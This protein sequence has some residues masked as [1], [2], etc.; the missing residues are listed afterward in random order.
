MMIS[1]CATFAIVPSFAADHVWED[2]E[3]DAKALGF[4]ISV[5]DERGLNAGQFNAGLTEEQVYTLYTEN[6]ADEYGNHNMNGTIA[7][8]GYDYTVSN[9]APLLTVGG[10]MLFGGYYN[11]EAESSIPMN[12]FPL[13]VDIDLNGEQTVGGIRTYGRIGTD[14]DGA[15]LTYKTYVMYAGESDWTFVKEGMS[16]NVHDNIDVAFDDALENVAKVRFQVTSANVVSQG[17]KLTKF[18][19]GMSAY[20]IIS[21]ITVLNEK[22]VSDVVAWT[23]APTVTETSSGSG[24]V[25]AN[26]ANSEILFDGNGVGYFNSRVY[27]WDGS[28][29]FPAYVTIDLGAEYEFSAVRIYGRYNMYGQCINQG[30]ISFSNN[31]TDWSPVTKHADTINATKEHGEDVGSAKYASTGGMY[32]DMAFSGDDGKYNA[33]GRYIRIECTNAPWPQ[34]LM[35]EVQLVKP[36]AGLETK[37]VA[38]LTGGGTEDP[39]TGIVEWTT[40]PTVTEAGGT[41][42]PNRTNSAALFDGK[43]AGNES[44]SYYGWEYGSMSFPVYFIVDLGK[45]YEFSAVRLYGRYGW[46]KQSMTSGNISVSSDGTTWSPKSSHTDTVDNVGQGTSYGSTGANY[47]DMAF[48]NGSEKCNARARYI[49]VECT[50]APWPQWLM[51]E[52]QL[53][54]PVDGLDYLTDSSDIMV[55]YK[56]ADILDWTKTPE[57]KDFV[58]SADT[59][60]LGGSG[61]KLFD[62]KVYGKFADMAKYKDY[63]GY[64]FA[65]LDSGETVTMT[66]DLGKEY[67]FSAVRVF[68][69]L[70]QPDQAM[71]QGNLYISDDG[72]NWST[73]LGHSDAKSGNG[74][75][76]IVDGGQDLIKYASTNNIYTDMVGSIAAKRV[77]MRARYIK[78]EV[79]KTSG[80]HF[81]MQEIM[82]VKPNGMYE[83][84]NAEEINKGAEEDP[85]SPTVTWKTLPT[86][87]DYYSQKTIGLSSSN[88]A[89]L[90]DGIVIREGVSD[91]NKAPAFGWDGCNLNSTTDNNMA[92]VTIDLGQEYEFSAVRVYGRYDIWFQ[93]MTE[94]NLFISSDSKTD[95]TQMWSRPLP[96]KDTV[97][98]TSKVANGAGNPIYGSSNDMY[99]DLKAPDGSNMKARYIRIQATASGAYEG[100]W[101]MQEIQ[102]VKPVEGKETKGY[103]DAALAAGSNGYYSE[104]KNV[105]FWD[106]TATAPKVIDR[107]TTSTKGSPN[108]AGDKALFDKIVYLSRAEHSENDYSAFI[109]NDHCLADGAHTWVTVDLGRNYTFSAIRLFPR[110]NNWDNSVTEANIYYSD[111]G[112]TW[113]APMYNKDNYASKR[114]QIVTYDSTG[115]CYTDLKATVADKNYNITARYIKIDITKAREHGKDRCNHVAIQELM[116]V[117]P[118]ASNTTYTVS[119][120]AKLFSEKAAA[121]DALIDAIGT[122]TKDSGDAIKKARAAY[123]ALDDYSKTLVTKLDVLEKAEKDFE[124][125]AA[126]NIIDAI[127]ALPAIGNVSYS[128]TEKID[129]VYKDYNAL[130]DENKNKITNSAKLIAVKAELAGLTFTLNVG[131]VVES[132]IG[133]KCAVFTLGGEK[134]IAKLIYN[135]V[136]YTEAD[137]QFTQAAAD[138]KTTLTVTGSYQADN[139]PSWNA[140][141]VGAALK[142]G[143]TVIINGDNTKMGLKKGDQ[144]TVGTGR[145]TRTI[146]MDDPMGGDHI[147]TVEYADGTTKTVNLITT[148]LTYSNVSNPGSTGASDEITPTRSWRYASASGGNMGK[149][150][151]GK[152]GDGNENY[153]WETEYAASPYL[154]DGTA[155]GNNVV[156]YMPKPHVFY[157]DLKGNTEGYNGVR[158]YNRNTG[159]RG[160]TVGVTDVWGKMAESDEWTKLGT[161]DLTGQDSQQPLTLTF[162]EDGSNVDYRFLMFS[163]SRFWGGSNSSNL[164]IGE[165]AIVKPYVT[166]IG[167]NTVITDVENEYIADISFSFNMAEAKSVAKV[168][169]GGTDIG[170]ANWTFAGNTITIAADYIKTLPAGKT[171]LTVTFNNGNVIPIYIERED[172]KTATYYITGDSAGNYSRGSDTLTLTALAGKTVSEIVAKGEKLTFSQSGNDI[173]IT[174]YNFRAADLWENYKNDGYIMLKIT[175]SDGTSADYRVILKGTVYKAT[176]ISTDGFK[177]DE[178]KAKTSWTVETDS[179]HNSYNIAKMF[180]NTVNSS[181]SG[182]GYNWHS[183]YSDVGGG[184]TPDFRKPHHLEIDFGELTEFSGI[185]YYRRNDGNNTAGVWTAVGIYGRNDVSEEWTEIK[186]YGSMAWPDVYTDVTL[187]T[188]VK[189]RYVRLVI[190]GSGY[191]PTAKW[192]R[193]L[194]PKAAFKGA[195]M[196]NTVVPMDFDLNENA[197]AKVTLNG[198]GRITKLTHEGTELPAEYISIQKDQASISPYYFKDNGYDIGDEVPFK[199]TFAFGPSID[200]T[201]K[202]GEVDGHIMTYAAGENGTLKATAYNSELDRTEDKISGDKVRN[203]DK[204]TFTATADTGYMVDSWTVESTTP[205]FEIIPDSEKRKWSVSASS[206]TE[207]NGAGRLINGVADASSDYWHSGYTVVDGKPVADPNT[208]YS[209]ELDFT[210]T[211]EGCIERAGEFSYIPRNQAATGVK[212]YKLYVKEAGSDEWTL[213]AEGSF[214]NNTNK[215]TIK[216]NKVCNITKL[217]YVMESLYG[218]Y[219]YI[220]EVYVSRE[221]QPSGTVVRRGT[222]SEDFMIDDRFTDMLVTVT[223][224]KMEAGTV[225]VFTD[226]KNITADAPASVATGTDLTVNLTPAKG[227]YVSEADQIEVTVDGTALKAGEDYTYDRTSDEAAVLTIKNVSGKKL[228]IKATA[229]DYL[230]RKVSY[231]DVLGAAGSLPETTEVVEGEEFTVAKSS[232]KLVGYKFVGWSYN[233]E[234]YKAGDKLTMGTEDIVLSAVWEKDD[235][236][237]DESGKTDKP[238]GGGSGGGSSKPSGGGSGGGI[239]GGSD[240]AYTVTING[241]S[242]KVMTGTVIAAPEA[243]A[244]YTFKGY[245]LDEA[246]TVPYANDG[247]KANVTLYPAFEKNRSRD[248]LTDI[249]G[250]WAEEYIVS[251][252]EKSIVSGSG[253]GK[254]NPDSNI[255]RAEFVQILYNMSGMTSDGSYNFKDVKPGDWFGQAVAWAV[256]FG[257]TSGISED[258]FSP[259]ENI[260]REQMAAMIYRYATLMGADWQTGETG[261]F[262]DETDIADYAKYQVRWAKGEGIISGR[263]D[264]SFGPKDNAT[265]AES[266]AMLSRLVK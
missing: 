185:R 214:P 156:W 134:Q 38:D 247:V 172:I 137:G 132:Q 239:G 110:W 257:I 175:F 11:V 210:S 165:I 163:V 107:G 69:K 243:P 37:T 30:S 25:N 29:T 251:L 231:V 173:T 266:A 159:A 51:Q 1:L 182:N 188:T 64:D 242:T 136:S 151:D 227:Y 40:T 70:N 46:L 111:D 22:A 196:A 3:Y 67:E 170:A 115:D 82:L 118:V 127:D 241:V 109:A 34:W 12:V 235:S 52:L 42:E 138:G 230:N 164:N 177:S 94:G 124:V 218:S 153:F 15:V 53:V 20:F 224:K 61:E 216:F 166:V 96:F 21:G 190:Q 65:G 63:Y 169:K 103:K 212:D 262:T 41:T 158:F 50:N 89:S 35:Q 26:K 131:S 108:R 143:K 157:I 186:E 144:I 195:E 113:S 6:Y 179:S 5:T 148:G 140:T 112:E 233:G 77:N 23:T 176:G 213:V 86:L 220:S 99:T 198:A 114:V 17:S 95:T 146:A 9:P 33:K 60:R 47:T 209:I 122:V 125:F 133:L 253:D 121:V 32:T 4:A 98:A 106:E 44:A 240:T 149:A 116:M 201:V 128:D 248:D 2:D 222:A 206:Q 215:K 10:D 197:V 200:F 155:Y 260:T 85:D 194:T 174:R 252:Y 244:G 57:V 71:I 100:G 129:S 259:Y 162:N 191:Y 18:E 145:L 76:K 183:G 123:D 226:L 59:A 232:L 101:W 117:K 207:H 13:N 54:K 152:W 265:R 72:E 92:Y 181:E 178:I 14:N 199:L 105:L 258:M 28:V 130:S 39:E 180:G 254:F 255:T 256:N 16:A 217:K 81:G 208:P 8:S 160:T 189:C 234:T 48:K 27:G 150:F 245:Y 102:L 223:F 49:R 203:T 161:Y 45:E 261:E 238:S 119:E 87:T 184:A 167:T 74:K 250:H 97:K 88:S 83:T 237:K 93:S 204:L 229:K 56:T 264:G 193:F 73:A 7:E 246:L 202:V 225:S 228:V 205:L 154:I 79:L 62:G 192:L 31:G 19:T 139:Y 219:A 263:P 120:L 249:K 78:I 36:V 171:E 90:F 141:T 126:Q 187:A 236:K 75:M 91:Y 147:V 211:N 55:D 221:K 66:A 24:E 142:A 104:A 84:K 168:E 43:G 68:G 80:K 58:A 135:G